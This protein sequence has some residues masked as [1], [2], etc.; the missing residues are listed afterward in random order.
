MAHAHSLPISED[1]AWR[2]DRVRLAL[3][4]HKTPAEIDAM[5][6]LDVADVVEVLRGEEKI[7]ELEQA[8]ARSRRK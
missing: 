6:L 3:K 4:L 5:P 7:H 2:V 1:E 8:R